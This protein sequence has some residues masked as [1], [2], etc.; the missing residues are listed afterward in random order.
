MANGPG[1]VYRIT[2]K[3][4][5]D[6]Q[7]KRQRVFAVFA[8]LKGR[9]FYLRPE[10]EYGDRPGVVSL[11]LTDGTEVKLDEFYMDMEEPYDPEAKRRREQDRSDEQA[12]ERYGDGDDFG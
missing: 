3:P 10:R 1:P 7:A 8:S 9:G 11:I 5:K 6:K 2:I 12:A 4:K